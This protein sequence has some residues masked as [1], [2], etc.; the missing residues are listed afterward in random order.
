M[1]VSFGV[2]AKHGGGTIMRFDDTNPEAEKPEYIRSI[3]GSVSWL[4][5]KYEKLTYTSD[6]FEE[7]YQ[8]AEKLIL[9]DKAYVCAQT[10]EEVKKSRDIL[11]NWHKEQKCEEELLET[12][13]EDKEM[14]KR[15]PD[16]AMSPYRNRPI[17]ESLKLFR[18]MRQGLFEE[19][20]ITLRMKQ[21]LLS[22]NANL[23][24]Q[25]AYRI[26]YKEHPHT[27]DKWCIYP[28]YDYSHC[29]IDS[30][31]NITHSLCSLEF[32]S[33]QST[34]GS[35]HWLVYW[36]DLYH[37]QTW[38]FSRCSISANVMSKRRLNRLVTENY[39]NGWDDPR[40]LTLDGLKRR[41]VT[42]EAINSFCESIGVARSSNTVCIKYSVLEHFVRKDL[43]ERVERRFA[44]IDPLRVV[45]KGYSSKVTSV[46]RFPQD[47]TK[48]S[49]DVSIS[50]V[51]LIPKHKFRT[52]EDVAK[53]GKK[54]YK[55]LMKGGMAKLLYGPKIKCIDYSEN[56]VICE[57]VS[58]ENTESC[59]TIPWVDASTSCKVEG[60]FFDALFINCEVDGVEVHA[61][62]ASK[63]QGK[64]YLELLNPDSLS[65]QEITVEKAVVDEIHNWLKTDKKDTLRWQ[66]ITV[67]YFCI[68]LDTSANNIV[69]NRV[70]SLKE[71]KTLR[72]K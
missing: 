65:K 3:L 4:Q 29:L 6:Y 10:K 64:E 62:K 8:L 12:L 35:Y 66:F 11:S 34:Y 46:P 42:P 69:L 45:I 32:E 70:V 56:E 53:L 39:V 14:L 59:A 27:G 15:L 16:G 7:L 17:E 13:E 43:N 72:K 47:T 55:G 60:R 37:A 68:D 67:G 71:N 50:E 23:W 33:R 2:A 20:S 21:N 51:V 58:E 22:P 54:G 30:L 18:Q 41:G 61:E 63:A 48:G 25:M 57:V 1:L 49:R 24:D 44:I 31:E 38:E 5:H 40:L 19:R 36:L 28:T 52:E 26:L 9:M